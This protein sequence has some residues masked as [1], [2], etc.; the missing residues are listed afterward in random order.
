MVG[1]VLVQ[2]YMAWNHTAAFAQDRLMMVGR[3]PAGA[4]AGVDQLN[5]WYNSEAH[6]QR[7]NTRSWWDLNIGHKGPW[8]LDDEYVITSEKNRMG[9]DVLE[10]IPYFSWAGWHEKTLTILK[11]SGSDLKH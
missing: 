5:G 10:R 3:V 4:I 11:R 7:Y 9:Y 2:D 8:V 1:L 6:M